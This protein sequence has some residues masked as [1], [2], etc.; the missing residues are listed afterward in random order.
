MLSSELYKKIYSVWRYYANYAEDADVIIP[1][2]IELRDAVTC[3]LDEE[4]SLNDVDL[5]IQLADPT[6]VSTLQLFKL[7]IK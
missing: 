4:S 3:K 7:K 2:Y 6:D 5:Q 1:S